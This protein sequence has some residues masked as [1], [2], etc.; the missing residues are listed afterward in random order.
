MSVPNT[1]GEFTDLDCNVVPQCMSRKAIDVHWRFNTPKNSQAGGGWN[2]L[3]EV[4]N[5]LWP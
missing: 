4:L 1:R 3:S 5:V 2:E